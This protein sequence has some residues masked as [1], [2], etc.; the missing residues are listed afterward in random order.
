MDLIDTLNIL[1]HLLIR[2]SWPTVLYQVFA[3]RSYANV[4][5]V[6]A[7]IHNP[8]CSLQ[9]I[10]LAGLNIILK[11]VSLL[12]AEEGVIRDFKYSIYKYFMA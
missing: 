12:F 4:V 10:E 1:A 5:D 7:S 3:I 2:N 8:S 6:L 9:M 11:F